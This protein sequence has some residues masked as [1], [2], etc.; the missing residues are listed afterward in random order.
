V[1]VKAR[2]TVSGERIWPFFPEAAGIGE[3]R[4]GDSYAPAVKNVSNLLSPE[5]S[6]VMIRTKGQGTPL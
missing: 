6:T 3:T 5:A 2:M 4:R 1:T